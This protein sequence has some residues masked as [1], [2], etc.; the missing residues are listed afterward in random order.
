MKSLNLLDVLICAGSLFHRRFGNR[1]NDKYLDGIRDL[2]APR[3]AGLA[4]NLGMGRGIF[5]LFVVNSGNRHC[6]NKLFSGQSRSCLLSNQS[7]ECAWLTVIYLT[8][9]ESILLQPGDARKVHVV[10]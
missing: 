8:R 7:K 6:P 4:Q 9:S 1:E 2:I 3:E 10:Y 5:R